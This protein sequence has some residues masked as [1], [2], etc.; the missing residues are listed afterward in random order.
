VLASV[1]TDVFFKLQ[2]TNTFGRGA[3]NFSTGA[4]ADASHNFFIDPAEE[5]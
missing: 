5:H 4:V 3:Y 1:A 2:E